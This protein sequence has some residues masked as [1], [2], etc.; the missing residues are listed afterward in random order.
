MTEQEGRGEAPIGSGSGAVEAGEAP[1]TWRED[2]G[3]AP[4][5]VEGLLQA[6]SLETPYRRMG[7][8]R[9]VLLLLPG[10]APAVRDGVFRGLAREGLVVEPLWLP[11]VETWTGWLQDLVEG[12]G[13]EHPD[14]MAE[15]TVL[16]AL[17]RVAREAPETLGTIRRNEI[18]DS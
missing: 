1:M 11:P 5:P 13:L 17:E 15:D 9:P 4:E 7:R 10:A 14:V 2:A 18:I 3:D 12:L 16:A 6:G 8:G